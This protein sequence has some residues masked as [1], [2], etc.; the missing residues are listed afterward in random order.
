MFFAYD[1]LQPIIRRMS[2]NTTKM[3]N[4]KYTKN[5]LKILKL[6]AKNNK[7]SCFLQYISNFGPHFPSKSNALRIRTVSTRPKET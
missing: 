2:C 4:W 3:D 6:L 1:K 7:T 5:F